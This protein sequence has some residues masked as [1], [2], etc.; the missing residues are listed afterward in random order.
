MSIP[1][2]FNPLG[3]LGGM[4]PFPQAV[5]TSNTTGRAVGGS[6]LPF[7]VKMSGGW[8]I[9]PYRAMDGK[10]D[11]YCRIDDV[12]FSTTRTSSSI[13][14]L[15]D[16]PV[17]FTRIAV[18]GEYYASYGSAQMTIKYKDENDGEYKDLVDV[19]E[20]LSY[21]GP[22][23]VIFNIGEDK[24]MV[25]DIRITWGKGANYASIREISYEAFYKP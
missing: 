10:T 12:A 20:K 15:F 4:L 9:D 8:M 13:I 22:E 1:T 18:T 19:Y 17:K 11:T 7:P 23:T 14:L 3:T 6:P 25:R 21:P 2:P 5:M 16:Y 24:P